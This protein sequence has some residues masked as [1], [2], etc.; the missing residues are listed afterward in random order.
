MTADEKSTLLTKPLRKLSAD[1]LS[2]YAADA[3]F[4]VG[5]VSDFKYF[6]PR[7]LELSVRDEFQW[8]DAEVVTR[9]LWL[10]DWLD[11][12]K[13]EHSVVSDLLKAKLAT[14]LEDP[15]TNGSQIDEWVCAFGRCLRDPTSFLEPLLEPQH[16]DK[17][18]AFIDQNGSLFTKNKL[19]NAFWED[20]RES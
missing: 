5:E 9:K 20:A 8:P 7:I 4:T 1:E 3:F 18:L 16:A 10:A 11:W 2:G 14:L 15:N 13:E 6:L 12:P 17:L 19:D